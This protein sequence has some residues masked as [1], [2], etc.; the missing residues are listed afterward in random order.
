MLSPKKQSVWK[1]FH[2]ILFICPFRNICHTGFPVEKK[3]YKMLTITLIPQQFDASLCF[4]D[5][6]KTF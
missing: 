2:N 4:L 6:Y 1:T 5:G 3:L